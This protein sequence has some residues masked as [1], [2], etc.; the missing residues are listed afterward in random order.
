MAERLKVFVNKTLTAADLVGNDT[1]PLV[2]TDA[3]TQ[4]V[5]RDIE[6]D[7]A[8]SNITANVYLDNNGY[9]LTDSAV[10]VAGSEIV[11]TNSTLAYKLNPPILTGVRNASIV[12]FLYSPNTTSFTK[13]PGIALLDYSKEYQLVTAQKELI[14]QKTGT[15]FLTT[16]ATVSIPQT[17]N[18]VW[19]FETDT[20]AYYFYYDGNS[21]TYLY[22]SDI[23]GGVYG[24]WTPVDTTAYAYKALDPKN[25]RVYWVAGQSLYEH[26]MDTNTTT[27][28]FDYAGVAPSI[29]STY[30]T[31]G[32]YD[33]V[34][35]GAISNAYLNTLL[36]YDTA[37]GAA[38]VLYTNS[39][40]A[41]SIGSFLGVTKS[42]DG[43]FYL[44]IG[45]DTNVSIF[46]QPSNLVN[47]AT[48]AVYIGS[49]STLFP[50]GIGVDQWYMQGFDN[51]LCVNNSVNEFEVLKVD[52]GVF[53]SVYTYPHGGAINANSTFIPAYTFDGSVDLLT[54]DYDLRL[55]A[56]V[57]GVE[58][59]GV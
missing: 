29:T 32:V 15:S 5:V 55:K 35:F 27:L 25:R 22:R 38:G 20:Y 2:Q 6:V 42:V 24:A 16:P 14:A 59:A 44:A 54:T 34:Y 37:T 8:Q 19:Y 26:D 7:A 39:N 43:D 36:F 13:V 28:L 9:K 49:P 53:S 50:N 11:D 10:S 58:I 40:F 57:S 1:L 21:S 31:A 45:Y 48:S 52:N 4:A 47:G 18:S 12:D 17:T 41:L 33:G 51:H 46:R 3:T 30:T 56:K 23:T